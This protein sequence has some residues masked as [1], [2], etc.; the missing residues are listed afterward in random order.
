MA[1]RLTKGSS[2]VYVGYFFGDHI[3]REECHHC[4]L[5]DENPNPILAFSVNKRGH[6]MNLTYHSIPLFLE[7]IKIT[8][9]ITIAS[10][11][12]QL[13]KYHAA[14]ENHLKFLKSEETPCNAATIKD[15]N[16]LVS[17]LLS[18]DEPLSSFG[19]KELYKRGYISADR[20]NSFRKSRIDKYIDIINEGFL[21]IDEVK[22]AR[23][24]RDHRFLPTA[25]TASVDD[26]SHRQQ[27]Q[28]TKLE[29]LHHEFSRLITTTET[30]VNPRRM[31]CDDWRTMSSALSVF[32]GA[33]LSG[34]MIGKG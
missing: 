11:G 34:L 13:L 31:L 19:Y 32:T 4:E 7:V 8:G 17:G 27:P 23:N 2:S 9:C 12:L 14:L 15:L 1:L 29:C 22:N 20:M 26:D 33:G 16:L 5:V 18:G 30:F 24:D 28:L 6:M 25:P 10:D 3:Y 21:A